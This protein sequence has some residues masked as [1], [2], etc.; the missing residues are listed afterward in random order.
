M[1]QAFLLLT[2]F[3]PLLFVFVYSLFEHAF[4]R[5]ESEVSDMLLDWTIRRYLDQGERFERYGIRKSALHLLIEAE[6]SSA[7]RRSAIKYL[8][9]CGVLVD[10]EKCQTR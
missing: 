7:G 3:A 8:A 2:T 6:T 5:R 1:M 10:L 9:K 4:T